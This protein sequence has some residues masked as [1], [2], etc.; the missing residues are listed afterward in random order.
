VI[1]KG[2]QA[3]LPPCVHTKGCGCAH[4]IPTRGTNGRIHIRA[5]GGELVRVTTS[6][7]RVQVR[8]RCLTHGNVGGPLPYRTLFGGKPI[9]ARGLPERDPD[10]SAE[11]LVFTN[12][13]TG[14][15]IPEPKAGRP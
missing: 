10:V 1:A 6:D 14:V 12:G 9:D 8:I 4:V 3:L 11:G 15:I 5:P 7:Y 2:A 13:Q